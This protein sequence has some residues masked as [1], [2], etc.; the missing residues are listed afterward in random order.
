VAS[1]LDAIYEFL[2]SQGINLQTI[3]LMTPNELVGLGLND[4]QLVVAVHEHVVSRNASALLATPLDAP[5]SDNEFSKDLAAIYLI[6]ARS[7]K[8][9]VDEIGARICFVH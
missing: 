1:S 8:G 6:P 3:E 4:C 2:D 9:R 5:W 7:L